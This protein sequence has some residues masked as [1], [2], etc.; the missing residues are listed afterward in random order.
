MKKLIVVV[1][2]LGAAYVAL[3]WYTASQIAETAHQEEIERFRGYVDLPAL[4]ANLRAHMQQQLRDSVDSE[5]SPELNEFLAAGANL[6]LGPLLEGLVTAEGLAALLRGGDQLWQFERELYRQEPGGR[7]PRRR[8][9]SD[10]DSQLELQGWHFT[11][12]D[13]AAADYGTGD[14]AELRLILERQGLHW[15]VVDLRFP[16]TDTDNNDENG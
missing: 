12:F 16:E 10:G 3:P 8:D 13:R 5:V 6:F 7:A 4:R 2:L 15:R 11:A 14:A 1:L 9:A